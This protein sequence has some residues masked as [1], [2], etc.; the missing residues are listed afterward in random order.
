MFLSDYGLWILLNL[1]CFDVKFG[2]KIPKVIV[3]INF[4][5]MKMFNAMLFFERLYYE[6]SA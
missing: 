4:L 2:A 1:V 5:R 6:F 3:A